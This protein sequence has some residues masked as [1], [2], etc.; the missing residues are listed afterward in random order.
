MCHVQNTIEI[1]SIQIYMEISK[2]TKY[3]QRALYYH[4]IHAPS[5][6]EMVAE[7]TSCRIEGM[8][9]QIQLLISKKE[10]TTSGLS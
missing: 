1:T 6:M 9:Q 4:Q 2:E 8:G 7:H 5:T 3:M 10:C